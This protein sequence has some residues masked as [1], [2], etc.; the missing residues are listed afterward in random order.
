MVLE[1]AVSIARE[2]ALEALA[3][4]AGIEVSEDEVKAYLRE[5]AEQAGEDADALV[6]DVW[7]HGQQESIREDL[8]LRAALERLAA[9]VKPIAPEVADAREKLWTPDKEKTEADTKLWTPGS[10]EP[11]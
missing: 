4:R 5:E 11:A 8:R 2:L 7:A 6:E 10:K 1:A 9:D 3:D